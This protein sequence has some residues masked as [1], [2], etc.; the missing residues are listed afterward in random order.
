MALDVLPAGDHGALGIK[1]KGLSLNGFPAGTHGPGFGVKIVSLPINGHKAQPQNAV[2]AKIAFSVFQQLP[3]GAE[4][5]VVVKMVGPVLQGQPAGDL[6]AVE[7]RI[8]VDPVLQNPAAAVHIVI[9]PQPSRCS[10]QCQ[11]QK[12]QQG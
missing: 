11:P 2:G 1:I 6:L 5:A 12:D 8:G 4:V 7:I 10:Q 3:A 9:I